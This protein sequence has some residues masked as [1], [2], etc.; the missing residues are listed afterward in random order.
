VSP[1]TAQATIAPDV[2]ANPRL[3][4]WVSVTGDGRVGIRVGKVELGQGIHTA[5]AQIAADALGIPLDLVRILPTHTALGPDQGLTAGSM[6]VA[7]A[8]PAVRHVG[9]VL[10]DH[11]LLLAARTWSVP[12][13]RV[14]QV[15]GVVRGPA[16]QEC[17]FADL[18]RTVDGDLDLGSYPAPSLEP[19]AISVGRSAA[20]SD[21]PD[22]VLGRPRYI[23]DLRP[24]GLLF[25]R[26][27]RPPGPG[28]R[29]RALDAT[30]LE[31]PARLVRDGS[32][33]AVVTEREA[34]ADPA[35]ES[36]RRAC[37]WDEVELLPDEDAVDSF[38]RAGPHEDLPLLDEP[39]AD[40]A[41]FETMVRASYSR[42]Y[43]VHAS[44]APSCGVAC[45]SLD[46]SSVHVW[47]HSQGVH[48]LRD[49]IAAALDLDPASVTVEH[50]ENAG[51]YGH[52]A[53]DDAAFDAVL[54][55]RPFAGRPVQVRWSR[56]DELSW[57]PLAS[58]MSIDLEAC[59]DGGRIRAWR[60]DVWSQ[61]HTSRPGYCGVP[62]LLAGGH[63]TDPLPVPAPDD[64]PPVAG[65]GTTRNA[66]PLYDVGARRI[67]GHRL[68]RTPL[69]TSAMRALGSHANVFAIESFMD[70]LALAA[71]TDAL[72]FRLAHLSDPRGR[73]VLEAAAAHSG[74]GTPLADDCGRGIGFARYKE[75]GAYCAV[76][77]QVRVDHAVH[78]DLLTAAV[79]VGRVI[80]PD[81]VRN[82]IEGG[83]TQATSWTLKERVRFDRSRI[84][85]TDWETY[86]I[87]RFTEAPRVDV[88]LL[89]QPDLPS[90]GSG[91]AAQGPTAAALANAVQ[92]ALGVR[93]RHLPL[94]PAAIVAAIERSN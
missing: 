52:N 41:A 79:D 67:V 54:C 40:G 2:L 56:A 86:P 58:A 12:V 89:D 1:H 39:P 73:A 7:Q 74:W 28:A 24:A 8:G 18:A 63:L 15:E 55:A 72:E 93:V 66:I 61:G 33:V 19:V 32:F 78:V 25:G 51:C 60:A 48:R 13:D 21:L 75:K 47:S 20:R 27:L 65:G 45:W 44:I 9:A 14:E 5:L 80:N 62:G 11:V 23:S 30:V 34:D 70:E 71:G 53:A 31:P 69:R 81:G 87:L 49:A 37:T 90:L 26:V 22:K 94:T 50:V 88:H 46:G 10:R 85:S 43:L 82:Q 91:E 29:L 38:L 6:S 35:L 68:T 16:G 3:G 36:L 92:D 76:V 42:P 17:L 83:A 84:T 59:L 57:A 64:P 4:T 77:A